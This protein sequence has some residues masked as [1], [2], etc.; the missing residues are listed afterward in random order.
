MFIKRLTVVYLLLVLLS[1]YG[2]GT[3]GVSV[4]LNLLNRSN[5]SAAELPDHLDYHKLSGN[6]VKKRWLHHR[7][8]WKKNCRSSEQQNA[9][10][11][12]QKCSIRKD[13]AGVWVLALRTLKDIAARQNQQG[14]PWVTNSFKHPTVIA[15]SS[16]PEKY[17]W[18]FSIQSNLFKTGTLNT[19]RAIAV[20]Y[21][22][23]PGSKRVKKLGE[24]KSFVI[25]PSAEWTNCTF[26]LAVPENCRHPPDGNC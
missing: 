2:S 10:A 26:E 13:S 6:E 20:F 24:G 21:D 5:T 1:C 7:K 19:L 14:E 22:E 18:S 23:I 15:K 25:K 16:V 17:R 8:V 4:D 12:A 3:G 9:L 11:A